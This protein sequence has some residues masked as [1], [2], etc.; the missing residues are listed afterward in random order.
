MQNTIVT[1]RL[2]L[3]ALTAIDADF[4]YEL[5]NT[6][7]WLK[8]I[9]DRMV[10]TKEKAEIF[11][12]SVIHSLSVNYWVVRL[13]EQNNHPIGIVSLVK[14]DFLDF[15][16]VGFAFLPTYTKQGFAFEAT[17]ALL[18]HLAEENGYSKILATTSKDNSSSISLLLKLGFHFDR[19][20]KADGEE[21]LIYAASTNQFL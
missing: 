21:L 5:V 2:R 17:T 4:I 6:P 13:H 16:D 8:F 10:S 3:T 9:G 19:E 1:Q 7:D 14:R 15:P 20:L 18:R 11:V 12:R